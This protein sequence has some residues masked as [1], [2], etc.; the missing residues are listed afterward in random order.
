MDTTFIQEGVFDLDYQFKLVDRGGGNTSVLEY[1]TWRKD[2]LAFDFEESEGL[3]AAEKASVVNMSLASSLNSRGPLG[4]KLSVKGYHGDIVT[5][6][7]VSYGLDFSQTALAVDKTR[8]ERPA[9]G[10][11]VARLTEMLSRIEARTSAAEERATDMVTITFLPLVCEKE[12]AKGDI[13]S[14]A[15]DVGFIGC[16]VTHQVRFNSLFSSVYTHFLNCVVVDRGICQ[17]FQAGQWQNCGRDS[18]VS[19]SHAGQS[20]GEIQGAR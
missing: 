19:A 5:G 17:K 15:Y 13:Y 11:S 9:G 20:I 7:F 14:E 12:L 10:R 16:S 4:G 6:P 18:P 1:Q 2:G 3:M 8:L